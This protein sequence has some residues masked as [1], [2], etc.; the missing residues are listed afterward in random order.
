AMRWMVAKYIRRY[1]VDGGEVYPP[2]CG[3]WWRSIS[4]AMRWMVAKYIR[5]YAVDGGETSRKKA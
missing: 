3:G 1:A 4:A 5:R 2:L